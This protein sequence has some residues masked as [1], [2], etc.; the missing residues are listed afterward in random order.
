[1]KRIIFIIGLMAGTT[2][3]IYAQELDSERMEKLK[4]YRVSYITNKVNLTS[5][6]AQKFWPLF[7]ELTDEIEIL[8]KE[9]LEYMRDVRKKGLDN[10]SEEELKEVIEKNFEWEQSELDVKK[11]YGKEFQKVLPIRKVALYYRAEKEFKKDLLERLG[12]GRDG[13]R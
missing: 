1:M 10:L 7:N 5:E 2:L 12:R 9:R 13:R 11:K 8:K 3:S 6:E 4:A